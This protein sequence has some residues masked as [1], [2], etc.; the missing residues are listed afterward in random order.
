MIQKWGKEG[1]FAAQNQSSLHSFH[2]KLVSRGLNFLAII[3]IALAFARGIGQ[4]QILFQPPA[5]D[6]FSN[7][8]PLTG[9]SLSV[10]S[11]NMWA[12]SEPGEPV[13]GGD[14]ATRSTW[15]RWVAAGRG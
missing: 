3:I 8:I 1:I 11:L 12:S 2:N 9:Y 14:P 4:S 5:N 15:W 13:H 7:A 10:T 6:N